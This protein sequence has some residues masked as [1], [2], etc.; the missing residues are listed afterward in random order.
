M[1]ES[2]IGTCLQGECVQSNDHMHDECAASTAS[3]RIIPPRADLTTHKPVALSSMEMDRLVW[4]LR[5]TAGNFFII[6]VNTRNP[7][8]SGGNWFRLNNLS[9]L[10]DSAETLLH[11]SSRSLPRGSVETKHRSSSLNR[12]SGSAATTSHL[13]N[14]SP[15]RGWVGSSIRCRNSHPRRD[16]GHSFEPRLASTRTIGRRRRGEPAPSTP[17][18]SD[19]SSLSLI[20]SEGLHAR[21]KRC[22]AH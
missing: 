18:L 12:R 5:G 1:T 17:T 15:R 3:N 21:R 7:T 13:T 8:G 6:E 9:H 10:T 11:L 16:Y 4:I 2:Q 19:T 20:P 22:I 14:R